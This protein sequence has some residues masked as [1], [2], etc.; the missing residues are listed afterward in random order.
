M[1]ETMQIS[2][3]AARVNAGYTTEE[4]AKKI[5]KSRPTINKWENGTVKIDRANLYL[6]S[7]IYKISIDNIFLP[8]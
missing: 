3:K 5:G 1:S 7:E 6:L 8:Y 2:L 4:V